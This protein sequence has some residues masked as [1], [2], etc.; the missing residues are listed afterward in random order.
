MLKSMLLVK[1]LI[2]TT[3]VAFSQFQNAELQVNG[4]T[5]SMC[6]KATQKQLET[7][8]FIDSIETDLVN[9]TYV[10]HF[11]KD[12]D[13]SA[14]LIKRKVEDA[15]FSVGSLTLFIEFKEQSIENHY[16]HPIND[17]LYHFLD[18]ESKTLDGNVG[19]RIVDKGFISH[20]EY[21]QFRKIAADYP[22]YESGKMEGAD[23]VYH[24][25]LDS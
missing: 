25:T 16:H 5:C 18:V 21:K 15:G 12:E 6:S 3:V 19:L 23:R 24:V 22:C 8:G 17:D 4:L 11:K 9:T 13:I 14:D 10:L 20:K 7:I 1:V 2:L